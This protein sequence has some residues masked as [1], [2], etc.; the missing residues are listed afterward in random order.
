MMEYD[1]DE[2][3]EVESRYIPY[4]STPADAVPDDSENVSSSSTLEET[5]AYCALVES[6]HNIANLTSPLDT[7]V[8]EVST[9]R[10]M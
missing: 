6:S 7:L 9:C 4:T 8:G 5:C 10:M 2:L 3:P 1:S